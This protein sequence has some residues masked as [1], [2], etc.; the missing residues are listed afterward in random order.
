MVNEF[1]QWNTSDYEGIDRVHFSPTEIWVP[2]IALYNNG[3]D[4]IKLAG[5]PGK[6]VTDV[7]VKHDGLNTWSG[8]ATFK[9]NCDMQVDMWPFDEQNCSLAFGSFTYGE[10]LLRIKTFKAK[11]QLTNRFV[12]SGNWNITN[13]YF[14]VTETDHGE[15]CRFNFSEAVYTVQMKRKSLYY[16]FYLMIPC[17]ILTILAMSSFLIH[18]ESG[19]RI[20]FVTTVLLSMT[21]FLLMIPSFLPVTSDGVPV[22]GVLLQGTMIII[23]LVLFANIFTQW[24]YYRE[25][26]PPGWLQSLCWLCGRRKG[27]AEVESHHPSLVKS[28][29][30]M[31]GIEM[32]ESNRGTPVPDAHEKKTER[33]TY[34]W[35]NVS[36]KMDRLFFLFFVV[37]SI[38]A[39]SL[40]LGASV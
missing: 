15:C 34:T 33:R 35:Q 32:M 25:G 29:A 5:G 11:N 4:Q 36:I 20:G 9:A 30:T 1:L 2:D 23:T 8:P 16:T 21:V 24:I 6:F 14:E 3:D 39:Y 22:L 10:N 19:E 27:K 12:E 37:I 28:A 40:Y 18:V 38:I 13:I 26:S 7:A 31:E 17:I